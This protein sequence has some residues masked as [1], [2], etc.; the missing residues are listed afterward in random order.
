MSDVQQMPQGLAAI[1]LKL[2]RVIKEVPA[3]ERGQ[4]A[5]IG[6]DRDGKPKYSYRYVDIN[7]ILGMLKP[8]LDD[9]GLALSQPIMTS[10]YGDVTVMTVSTLLIDTETG[11]SLGFS[12]PSFVL[13]GDPQAV[14]GTITYYRRY[15]IVSLFALEAE[16]DDGAQASR[17]VNQP[18][19]R[20][21]A[22]EEIRTLIGAMPPGAVPQFQHDFR[23]R[24]GSGLSDLPESRHG[25]ALNWTRKWQVPPPDEAADITPTLTD[26]AGNPVAAP[27][28]PSGAPNGLRAILAGLNAREVSAVNEAL[29]Q[30]FGCTSSRITEAQ[31]DEAVA[32][33]EETLSELR[34]DDRDA[35]GY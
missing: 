3:I 13:K 9:N 25:E 11:D 18:G 19:R 22:E 15:G 20:T 2:A 26:G 32:V 14:G 34:G 7:S 24:F 30:R 6:E 17:A 35:H 10:N 29:K 23:E 5:N 4:T 31:M 8:I 1:Y 16:D 33:A 27:V 28:P 12:G 21:G